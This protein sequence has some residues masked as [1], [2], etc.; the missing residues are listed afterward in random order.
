MTFEI[1]DS[2]GKSRTFLDW[3]TAAALA[4]GMVKVTTKDGVTAM[5]DPAKMSGAK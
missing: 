1:T 3:G 5:I 2:T 4:A